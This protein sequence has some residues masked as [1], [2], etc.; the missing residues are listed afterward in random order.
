VAGPVDV[1][2]AAGRWLVAQLAA[3]HSPLDVQ[4]CILTDSGGRDAWAWARWLPHCRPTEGNCV[5]RLA[6]QQ[7]R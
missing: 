2:R 5:P 4:I 7:L 1:P 6:V 3:L